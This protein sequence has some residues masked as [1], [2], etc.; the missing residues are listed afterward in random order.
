MVGLG[1]LKFASNICIRIHTHVEP[2][3]PGGGEH[4]GDEPTEHGGEYIEVQ[5]TQAHILEGAVLRSHCRD[6]VDKVMELDHLGGTFGGNRKPTPFMCQVMKM[7]Q[8]Q[9]EK[10]LVVEFS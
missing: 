5:D 4:K 1:F 6:A 3:G 7:L 2:Y 9:P 8:I 10:N